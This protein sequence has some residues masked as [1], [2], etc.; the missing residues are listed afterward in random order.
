[1]LYVIYKDGSWNETESDLQASEY[2]SSPDWLVTIHSEQST[3]GEMKEIDVINKMQSMCEESCSPDQFEAWESLKSALMSTR[4]NLS[5][6]T[7]RPA[8][9]LGRALNVVI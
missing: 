6:P 1:M 7:Q 2:A 8:D 9:E 5:R 3:Q 4:K